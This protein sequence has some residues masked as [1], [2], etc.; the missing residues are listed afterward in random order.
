VG[1]GT[2]VGV[3]VSVAGYGRGCGCGVGVGS[4]G[5][6]VCEGYNSVHFIAVRVCMCVRASAAFCEK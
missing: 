3:G 2:C 6:G 4:M 5:R 1:M